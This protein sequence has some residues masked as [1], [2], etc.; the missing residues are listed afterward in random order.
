LFNPRSLVGFIKDFIFKFSPVEIKGQTPIDIKISLSQILIIFLHCSTNNS[1]LLIIVFN[2]RLSTGYPG[3]QN[4]SPC[5]K[6]VTDKCF[7]TKHFVSYIISLTSRPQC[8]SSY[9]FF[10][11]ILKTK[12]ISIYFWIC[13]NYRA[14]WTIIPFLFFF[15]NLLNNLNVEYR[16]FMYNLF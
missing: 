6:C 14:D 2:F 3:I 16:L 13:E 4:E 1:P 9:I 8:A 12:V 15:F 5:D 7:Y 10:F 11:L